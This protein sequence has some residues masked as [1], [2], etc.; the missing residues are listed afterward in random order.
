M[1]VGWLASG[2]LVAWSV[3]KLPSVLYLAV[4]PDAGTVWPEHLAVAAGRGVLGIVAGTAVLAV[5][6]QAYRARSR[7]FR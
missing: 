1:S 6:L 3:G 7:I 2:F 4:H 5:V